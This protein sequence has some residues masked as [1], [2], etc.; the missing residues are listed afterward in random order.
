MLAEM[1][2]EQF[3][4]WQLYAAQEPFGPDR[5]D[6]RAGIIASTI[7]NAHR[8]S[9]RRPMPFSAKDFMPYGG[10]GPSS[11]RRSTKASPVTDPGE[12]AKLKEM[13]R[14]VYGGPSS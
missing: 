12:W 1:S 8:D 14:A 2:L 5:A 3:R 7:A 10:D 11:A 13:A 4:S 9:K 6:L